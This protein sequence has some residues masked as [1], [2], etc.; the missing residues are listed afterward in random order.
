MQSQRAPWGSFPKVVANGPLG[1]LKE[2]PEYAAAKGGDAVAALALAQRLVT[3]V[4][5]NGI[6]AL[7]K[8]HPNPVLVPV[9]A[10]EDSGRNKIPLAVAAVL[11]ARLGLA[12][13]LG[14]GQAC[15]VGRTNKG[16]D[17]R[18][19][20]NPA[21]LGPV[22][23]GAGYI[24]IDDTLSMGGT[25]ASLRGYLIGGG[26]Q[27]LG[28]AVMTAFE[29]ATVL[30]VSAKMLASIRAKH[31]DAMNDL[32]VEEFGYGIE[33]LTQGEAGHLRAAQSVESMRIRIFDARN[34]AG[35]CADEERA[36]R[37]QLRG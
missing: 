30:P 23:C 12:V 11:S 26:A 18:L 16:S 28:A 33:Q 3:P 17:H 25:I 7:A 31:G 4:M 1:E 14:I 37:Q 5:I 36:R 32:W 19:V 9:L 13:E 35:L 29:A 27:V 22:N 21:F 34:A 8:D 15:K 6:A 10:E 2:Q 24:I 20:F